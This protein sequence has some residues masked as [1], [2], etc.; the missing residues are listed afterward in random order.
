MMFCFN[1]FWSCTNQF[2]D[3]VRTWELTAPWTG[4][5]IQVPVKFMT[6]DLD[7]V[8]T[9]PGVKE[10]IH[11]GG[12]AADVPYLL[13]VVVIEDAGHFVNQEKPQEVTAH[14]NDFFIKLQD[15]YKSF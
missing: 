10:Y 8:Y 11:G 5:K 6:G 7:M 12:F 9:T 2:L 1:A 4:A 15:K 13:E 3:D 14:I